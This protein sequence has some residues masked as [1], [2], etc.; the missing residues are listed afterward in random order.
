MNSLAKRIIWRLFF[1]RHPKRQEWYKEREFAK[2]YE[3]TGSP[4]VW[5]KKAPCPHKRL[6]AAGV[7]IGKHLYLIGG[8]QTLEQVHNS[9]D[10]FDMEAEE[11]LLTT[12]APQDLAQSHHGGVTDGRHI[13]L[14][15][16][17][18]GP[19]CSPATP[20]CHVFDT[21]RRSWHDLPP[22]PAPRYA[23]VCAYHNERIHMAGGSAED[24]FTPL[25]DHWSIGVKDGRAV[26][27]EWRNEPPIPRAGTHRAGRVI[28]GDWYVFGGQERDVRA[29]T[30]DPTYQ[31]DWTTLAEEMYRDVYR[32]SFTSREW[33]RCTDLPV[34]LSHTEAS[35]G[36]VDGR[37]L[38]FAGISDRLIIEDDIQAYDHMKDAWET[39][40]KLPLAIK[41]PVVGVWKDRVYLVSGQRQLTADNRSPGDVIDTVWSAPVPSHLLKSR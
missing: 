13:F 11:W 38:V 40:G 37:T 9:V 23:P 19:F 21:E 27:A 30:N 17:Q 34:P 10:V 36:T 18:L 15:S 39:V 32:Y 33:K 24:R 26:E 41:G 31:P 2:R 5:E 14:I 20:D 16:G 8:Y 6:E 3:A 1:A 35:L 7:Q 28:D 25:A 29:M 22:L 4:W 12:E